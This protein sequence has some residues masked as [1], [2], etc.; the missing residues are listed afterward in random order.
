M[1]DTNIRIPAAN[2]IANVEEYYFSRKLAEVR[3]LDKPGLRVINLGIGSPDL[4]P[5]EAAVEALAAT[6][7][8]DGSHGYQNYKGIPALRNAIAAF[9]KRTYGTNLDPE[10]MVLPLMGSKEGILHIMMAF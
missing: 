2:R 4:A 10:T 8:E 7:R 3:A 1:S 5:S 6:A 9:S